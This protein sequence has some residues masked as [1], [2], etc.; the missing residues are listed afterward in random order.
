MP[1]SGI[2]KYTLTYGADKRSFFFSKFMFLAI[3]ATISLAIAMLMFL[4]MISASGSLP[5]DVGA[6]LTSS[7]FVF[8]QFMIVISMGMMIS[9]ITKKK[10]TAIILAIAL[11]LGSMGAS[12]FIMYNGVQTAQDDFYRE[13]NYNSERFTNH[14]IVD[15]FPLMNKI[16][17]FLLPWV[18]SSE[19]IRQSLHFNS[20][21]PGN[22]DQATFFSMEIDLAMCIGMIF[23]Y[24]LIG[25]W[26]L[27]REKREFQ[28]GMNIFRRP[29]RPDP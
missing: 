2:L 6:F 15:H 22:F 25:Y 21:A 13:G 14:Y 19:A 28:K 8:I 18:A 5:L 1:D 27:S 17:V 11:M 23:F 20:E 3:L 24:V 9:L 26:L 7:F 4:V 10:T 12:T 29:S 16:A